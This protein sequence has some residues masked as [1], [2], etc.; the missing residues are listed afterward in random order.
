MFLFVKVRHILEPEVPK[1]EYKGFKKWLYIGTK[2][3]M[4]LS[5]LLRN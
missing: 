4:S 5:T 2:H 3:W 1:S